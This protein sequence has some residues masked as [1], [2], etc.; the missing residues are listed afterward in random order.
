VKSAFKLPDPAVIRALLIVCWR[1]GLKRSTRW[2]FWHHLI[3]ILWANPKVAEQYLAVCAHNEH[4]MDYREIV[5]LQ[6][7]HQLAA[8]GH[9]QEQARQALIDRPRLEIAAVTSP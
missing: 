8:Y 7:E 2:S 6:I 9:G 5:R 4:F 1:Q 3:H